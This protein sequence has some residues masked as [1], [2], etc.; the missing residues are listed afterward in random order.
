MTRVFSHHSF[1]YCEWG[2]SEQKGKNAR[3][4]YN[5]TNDKASKIIHV[6][7]LELPSATKISRDIQSLLVNQGTIALLTSLTLRLQAATSTKKMDKTMRLKLRQSTGAWHNTKTGDG[8][9]REKSPPI[10][11]HTA[12]ETISISD[13]TTK[14]KFQFDSHFPP[15]RINQH[16]RIYIHPG[17]QSLRYFTLQ[18]CRP[19][20]TQHP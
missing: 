7:S 17:D 16:F 20:W 14:Q 19:R 2:H 15:R 5:G 10:R 6:K 18:R 9:Q 3:K 12:S 8:Y 4:D 13:T 1:G 11:R